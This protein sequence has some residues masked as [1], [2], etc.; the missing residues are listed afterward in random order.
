MTLMKSILLGSAAGIVAVAS[1]QAADL[2]TRKAAPAEYVKICNVGG[3]AGFVIPGSDTCLKIGGYIT[4]HFSAGNIEN[5]FSWTGSS[6]ATIGVP[7]GSPVGTPAAVT[8]AAAPVLRGAAL[9][10][11]AS[12]LR[13]DIGFFTRANVS[14]D[15][16]T[17]TAYGVL[18]GYV[19]L[20]I[21]TGNGFDN[22]TGPNN[23]PGRRAAPTLTQ[24]PRTA[25]LAS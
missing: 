13:S 21:D 12:N 2:P 20:Q 8:T 5:G 6:G 25:I 15:T 18:R 16:R 4:A 22:G 1:A 14:L 11:S 10:E 23:L 7:A 9:T 19:E 24:P 3:M 17:N